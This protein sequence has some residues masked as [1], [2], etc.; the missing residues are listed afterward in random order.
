M[1]SKKKDV[2]IVSKIEIDKKTAEPIITK[3]SPKEL[4]ALQHQEE[5]VVIEKSDFV[6]HATSKGIGKQIAMSR[7]GIKPQK[8]ANISHRQKVFKNIFTISFIVILLGVFGFTIYNDFFTGKP[9][10]SWDAITSLLSRGSLFLIMAILCVAIYYLLKG[11][12][13]AVMC[14]KLTGKFHLRTCIETGVIGLYYNCITPLAVGGQPFEI[15]HLSKHGVH[16]GTASSLPI[17][18]FFTNQFALVIL[19]IIAIALFQTNALGIDPALLGIFPTIISVMAIIGMS[20]CM[21][22]PLMVVVFS[23]MPKTGARL[24]SFAIRLGGKLKLIKNPEDAIVKTV[25]SLF[26]NAKSIKKIAKSPLL[27]IITMLLSFGEQLA[28]FSLAFFTLRAFGYPANGLQNLHWLQE[29]AQITQLAILLSVAVSFIPTP[30]N[31]GAADLSFYLLFESSLIAGF[32]F[33]AMLVWRGLSFY[34]FIIIGFVFATI[35]K[36]LDNRKKNT[37]SPLE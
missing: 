14:K 23:L 20:L 11:L 7:L 35:K 10:P 13:L 6:E 25:K 26:N 28:N 24:V 31:S 19:G 22:M 16:G 9:L 1:C 27:L 3:L 30:G 5:E 2:P 17:I 21:I 18:A 34:S 29:W 4:L 32:A 15:Y 36:K 8:N 12:K 33:P 37:L